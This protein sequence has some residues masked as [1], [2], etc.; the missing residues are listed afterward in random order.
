MFFFVV[1]WGGL[2][3]AWGVFVVWG[4]FTIPDR[5][6]LWVGVIPGPNPLRPLDLD[7]FS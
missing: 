1:V 4:V 7:H 2:E 5:L 6:A 3:V